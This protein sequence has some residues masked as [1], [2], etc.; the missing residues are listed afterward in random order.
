MVEQWARTIANVYA[1]LAMPRLSPGDQDRLASQ[2]VER[3]T[4]PIATG[5]EWSTHAN[6][7]LNA[8]ERRHGGEGPRVLSV[9]TPGRSIE[10]G[11]CS[12]GRR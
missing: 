12:A 1:E 9:D 6:L 11:R 7:V 2:L 10:M 3:L 4:E 5:R 8:W